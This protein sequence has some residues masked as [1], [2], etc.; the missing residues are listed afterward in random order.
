VKKNMQF[1][2]AQGIGFIGMALMF[3]AFQQND[4]RKLLWIQAGAGM[5]FTVHFVILGAFTGMGMN[6]AAI[7]RNLIFAR[8]PGKKFQIIWTV[9]FIAVF[10]II[11]IFTWENKFSFFPVFAMSLATIVFSLKEP[12]LI[13]FLSLPISGFW[14]T[15]NIISFSIAGVLTESFVICSILIA[16]VRFDILT[17]TEK[18]K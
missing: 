7:P 17:K 3:L 10:V 5:I 8:K 14:I 15:Y 2:I 13:R 9:F 16:I 4:K 11:G 6:L 1:Y 18:L 12:R